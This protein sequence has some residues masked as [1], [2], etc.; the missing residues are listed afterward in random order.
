MC[1]LNE[2]NQE[3]WKKARGLTAEGNTAGEAEDSEFI[4]QFYT[5]ALQG[6]AEVAGKSVSGSFEDCRKKTWGEFCTFCSLVGKRAEDAID[7]DVVAFVHGFWLPRH[8]G[9]CRTKVGNDGVKTASASA[10]KGVINHLNKSFNMLGR[11]GEQNPAGSDA[12]RSYRE[13][14]RNMLHEAGVR[15]KRAVLFKEA[16]VNDFIMWLE[17]K[18][19]GASG[20]TR[21]SLLTDLA[22]VHY[23]WE[24]W[25]RGK[26]CG[27]V[28]VRQIAFDDHVVRAGW[29]KTVREEP[30]SVIPV[31]RG[32]TE[33]AARLIHACDQVGDPV[34]LGYLFRPLNERRNGFK[35]EPMSSGTMR[36]RIQQRLKEAGLYE[37]ETLHSFRRSAVQHAASIEGYN[38]ER[39]MQR[40]RWAS[41]AA[42]RLYIEEIE[43]SFPRRMR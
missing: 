30:S 11:Q 41:Y 14:Y 5:A 20:F 15:E 28:E 26:E 23:L 4:H 33:A 13:G 7:L 9:A 37:G 19:G 24:T 42:F 29:T 17:E 32:F 10:I 8:Q 36:R 6:A 2:S 21:C 31:E 16:K 1:R 34:G 39:L 27:S 18:V 25:S 22:I 43:A 40:G 35:P 3:I 38:V 12:V